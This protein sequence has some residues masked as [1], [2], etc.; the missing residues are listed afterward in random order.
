VTQKTDTPQ[1]NNSE[2]AQA[3]IVHVASSPHLANRSFTTRWMMLDVIIALVPALC[4]SVYVFHWHAVVQIGLC[5]LT[6]LAAEVIFTSMRGKALSL[7]DGSAVVTGLI[8]G[9][10]LPWSVPWYVPVIGSCVAV[11]LGK[12]V[13]G[14]LGFNLFNPA[15]VGR[16]FVM[17]SFARIMGAGAYVKETSQLLVVT[18]ATPLTALSAKIGPLFMGQTNGSLGETSALAILIGGLY[19]CIRRTASWEIPA[20]L[21]VFATI[22][23]GLGQTAGLTP[24]DASEHLLSGAMLFGAFFIATD[25]VTSPLTPKGKFIFGAG[26]GC[27]VMLIRIFSG[28]PEGMM[29]AILLMNAAVP[30]LNQWTAPRPLGGPPPVRNG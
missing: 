22:L 20:G 1:S 18:Q 21:L 9:M 25:P 27:L 17:L 5:V 10:S 4:V 2:K 13:F 12:V 29:F 23:A 24:F 16:T 19:L 30:L 26:V 8:L 11:G 7:G 14:G 15:M 3:P 6:C 28:Y